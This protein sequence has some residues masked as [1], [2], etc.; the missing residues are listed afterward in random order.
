MLLDG[1]VQFY[2]RGVVK[3]RTRCILHSLCDEA[4]TERDNRD[5]AASTVASGD[6]LPAP[7]RVCAQT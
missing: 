5:T 3:Y 7:T 6:G 2:A 1:A 4:A